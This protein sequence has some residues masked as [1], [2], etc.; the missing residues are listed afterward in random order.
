[1][2]YTAKIMIGMVDRNHVAV[3]LKLF[4]E[5]HSRSLVKRRTPCEDG[6]PF[7]EAGRNVLPVRI[8]A[9]NACTGA[10]AN[11]RAVANYQ[12]SQ[13]VRRTVLSAS[14]NPRHSKHLRQGY[15]AQLDC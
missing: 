11:R 2:M 8:A 12:D 15:Q 14:R 5:K 9:K 3:I 6:L 13:T 1:M 7:N 4:R 10:D